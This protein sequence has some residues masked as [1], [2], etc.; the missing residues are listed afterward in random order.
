ML[1]L[2]TMGTSETSEKFTMVSDELCMQLKAKKAV[3][4]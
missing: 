4:G 1:R 3:E 2:F